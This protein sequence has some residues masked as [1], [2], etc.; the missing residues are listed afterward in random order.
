M[1]ALSF[2]YQHSVTE[3]TLRRK[4]S[5]A[6]LILHGVPQKINVAYPNPFVSGPPRSRSGSMSQGKGS[7]SR[8]FYHQ[9][10]AVRK[11]MISTV[12]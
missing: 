2:F 4:C 10:K 11:T 12:S 7:G 6:A 3:P 8:S 9:A 1:E 5:R